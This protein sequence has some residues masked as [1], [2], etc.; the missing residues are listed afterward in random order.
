MD[1]Y[2]RVIPRVERLAPTL[3]PPVRFLPGLAFDSLRSLMASQRDVECPDATSGSAWRSVRR[4]ATWRGRSPVKRSAG[5]S[6]APSRLCARLDDARPAVAA[7]SG[8][9]L[10]SV[11]STLRWS[12]RRS[13]DSSRVVTDRQDRPTVDIDALDLVVGEEAERSAVG[14]PEGPSAALRASQRV[15]SASSERTHPKPP[16]AS[17]VR[18]NEGEVTSV[19]R[20]RNPES[21]RRG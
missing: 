18:G 3:R 16:G 4:P 21:L 8:R 2:S 5:S 19:W 10:G 20:Q 11:V 1:R 7:L 13:S 9:S 17:R 14:R 12:R 15:C 6:R